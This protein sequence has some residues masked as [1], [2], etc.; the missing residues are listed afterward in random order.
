MKQNKKKIKSKKRYRTKTNQEE[1]VYKRKPIAYRPERIV[2]DNLEELSARQERSLNWIVD[3]CV[4]EHL[5]NKG[6]L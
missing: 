4:R 5:K 3:F 2:Y 6:R 1:Q